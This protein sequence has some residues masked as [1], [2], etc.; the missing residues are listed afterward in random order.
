MN[1]FCVN[2]YRDPIN[3]Y[4]NHTMIISFDSL[5]E[6]QLSVIISLIRPLHKGPLLNTR[7]K[8]ILKRALDCPEGKITCP[9]CLGLSQYISTLS[10]NESLFSSL[11]FIKR[12]F[13]EIGKNKW[14]GISKRKHNRVHLSWRYIYNKKLHSNFKIISPVDTRSISSTLRCQRRVNLRLV[15]K[16]LFDLWSAHLSASIW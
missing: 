6:K 8:K 2:S 12:G 15:I 10:F 5:L 9:I 4:T 14:N 7:A 11:H 1:Q 16:L 13:N 3:I